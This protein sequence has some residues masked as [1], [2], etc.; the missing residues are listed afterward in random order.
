[1][2]KV[3]LLI[4]ILYLINFKLDTSALRLVVL[5]LKFKGSIL[6]NS[7]ENENYIPTGIMWYKIV[8]KVI[9]NLHI[10]QEN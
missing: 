2:G 3:Y 1:M 4:A 5:N 7:Q 9:P 10:K 8:S 6:S